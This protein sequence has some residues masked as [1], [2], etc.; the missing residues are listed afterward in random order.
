MYLTAHKRTV[1]PLLIHTKNNGLEFSRLG[2]SVPKRVGNAIKR[3]SLKRL[4]REA[5]RSLQP[6][7]PENIDVLITVRPHDRMH[8]D[9]YVAT[10][11]KGAT[12]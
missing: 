5:F 11:S 7:F 10:I 4:C 3:N 6:G 12:N 8:L 9:D 2:L 1:G